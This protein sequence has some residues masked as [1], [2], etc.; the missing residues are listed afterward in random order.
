R[1]EHRIAGQLAFELPVA[2]FAES[3]QAGQRDLPARNFGRLAAPAER[4]RV[5]GIEPHVFQ[6]VSEAR[7]LLASV[8]VE[9]DVGAALC[10]PFRVPV[11]LTVTREIY[12][13][14]FGG[15]ACRLLRGACRHETDDEKPR[16]RCQ[17]K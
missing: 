3:G 8:R 17:A 9:G 16:E 6:K 5:H 13:K 4:A 2:P 1:T 15:L 11:R 14:I 10:A 7:R 12:S